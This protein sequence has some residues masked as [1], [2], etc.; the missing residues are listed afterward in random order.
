MDCDTLAT[1]REL[2]CRNGLPRLPPP[3]A[4]LISTERGKAMK[5]DIAFALLFSGLAALT[6]LGQPHAFAQSCGDD[7]AMVADYQ[8]DLTTLVETTR[9]E[10]L[11][12]FE[13]AYHK[14]SCITKLTLCISLVDG[15]LDCLQKAGADPT[16]TKEQADA[17][18]SKLSAYATFKAKLELDKKTLKAADDPKAAKAIVEKFDFSN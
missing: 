4:T 2:G 1:I 17:A 3:P 6:F 10:S 18:K 5:R 9:K 13:R 11:A 16:L 15:L 7:V 14:K 12:E 8:K